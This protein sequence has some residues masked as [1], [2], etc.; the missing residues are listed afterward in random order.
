[1]LSWIQ[2]GSQAATDTSNEPKSKASLSCGD[3]AIHSSNGYLKSNYAVLSPSRW[4]SV[5]TCRL[6]LRHALSW[7]LT[8][9]LRVTLQRCFNA[10]VDPG[11]RLYHSIPC[12]NHL[13]LQ[14][15]TRSE[16]YNNWKALSIRPILLLI[17][18]HAYPIQTYVNQKS[19]RERCQCG[20]WDKTQG[21]LEQKCRW[22]LVNHLCRAYEN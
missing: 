10:W 18:P 9:Y 3:R 16:Q 21:V 1:M 14:Y 7:S 8:P 5:H 13:S 17:N 19:T 22:V 20:R 6:S 4:R 11:T 2:I 15:L 12:R